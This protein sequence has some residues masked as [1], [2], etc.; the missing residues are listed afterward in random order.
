MSDNVSGM[1]EREIKALDRLWNGE[2]DKSA[3]PDD[4]TKATDF[5]DR[6]PSKAVH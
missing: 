1:S 6:P 2:S 3:A 4:A 5:A